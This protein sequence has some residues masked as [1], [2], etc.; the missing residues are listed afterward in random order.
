VGIYTP[1]EENRLREAIP[2]TPSELDELEALLKQEN[3]RELWAFYRESLRA[4][5]DAAAGTL[6]LQMPTAVHEYGLGAFNVA[7][8]EELKKLC[9]K[10]PL[11]KD[12]RP[13]RAARV[14]LPGVTS[15]DGDSMKQGYQD[16][17][18][19]WT[20][21]DSQGRSHKLVV[22]LAFSESEEELGKSVKRYFKRLDANAPTA[23]VGIDVGYLKD[24]TST[25]DPQL[26]RPIQLD[27]WRARRMENKV[28]RFSFGRIDGDNAPEYIILRLSDF[29]PSDVL[30][31]YA[32]ATSTDPEL[33][34]DPE[35]RIPTSSLVQG[36]RDGEVEYDA[37]TTGKAQGERANAALESARSTPEIE[38]PKRQR[39]ESEDGGDIRAKRWKAD[40]EMGEDESG[41]EADSK[42]SSFRSSGADRAEVE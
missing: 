30:A 40:S 8:Q 16:P 15:S 27:I 25:A 26:C 14:Q 38:L 31:N 4:C 41:D 19:S 18:D 10:Y 34:A 5:Y 1:E 23:L 42:D 6:A 35:L 20:Y 3:Y 33:E 28:P 36:V 7:V 39:G 9:S 13:S 37:K 24:A 12:I 11:A 32:R 22:E 21:R 17:D 2:I 29:I